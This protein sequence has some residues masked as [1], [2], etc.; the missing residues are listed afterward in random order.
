VNGT[1]TEYELT[2]EDIELSWEII[3]SRADETY[4]KLVFLKEIV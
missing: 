1:L 2:N 3:Y 4:K